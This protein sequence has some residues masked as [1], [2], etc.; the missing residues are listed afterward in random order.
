ML[1]NMA[2]KM[3]S[4]DFRAVRTVLEASDF[5]HAPGPAVRAVRDLVDEPTWDDIQRLPETVSIFTS[6]DHGEHLRLLS[7]LW[8]KW[9]E[10]L[11]TDDGA[12][13]R[14]SLIA[15][16]EF[17][18]ATFNALHGFYRV[19]A[20]CLRSILEQMTV[21]ADCVLRGNEVEAQAWLDG[22]EQL[23][24]GKACEHLQNVY[25]NSRLR[26][27]FQQDDGKHEEGWIRA[28]HGS[29][30][31]YSHARPGFDALE[32]W[33]GS[34]G[35]IYVR[36]VFLWTVKMWL[37]TYAS[38]VILRRVALPSSPIIG[39]IFSQQLVCDISVLQKAANFLWP[40]T[41]DR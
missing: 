7:H 5:A 41:A 31:N 17:Q 8:G 12:L 20:N 1:S 4:T 39:D 27:I 10:V 21:A 2:Q 25:Q 11:P 32:M 23:L 26:R 15:T 40:T 34:N 13:H 33:E 24:F 22:T 36:K 28:L 35:P 29:L 19:T 3:P 16:D 9:V 18:A 37:F 14:A 30:S 6:N 38:C